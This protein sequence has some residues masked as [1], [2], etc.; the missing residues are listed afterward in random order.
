MNSY[1]FNCNQTLK[2]VFPEY[3]KRKTDKS[4]WNALRIR[5]YGGYG[6]YVDGTV[7]IIICKECADELIQNEAYLKVAIK[8]Y[9]GNTL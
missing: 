1:C 9:L 7:E 6:E 8:Q 3:S 2:P 5:F 4:F